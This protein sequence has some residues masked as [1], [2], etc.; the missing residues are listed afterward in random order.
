MISL[1]P[2]KGKRVLVLGEKGFIGR[3]LVAQLTAAGADA[4]SEGYFANLLNYEAV[5]RKV[6]E[7]EPDYIINAA[8]RNGGVGYKRPLTIFQYNTVI[9]LTILNVA[10]GCGVEK[11]LMPVASCAYDGAFAHLDGISS[12]AFLLG[13]P[14]ESIE[15]HGYAK[16]ATQLACKFAR[17]QHGLRAVTVCPSTVFGSGDRYGPDRSKI[18]AGMVKRFADAADQGLESVTCWGTGKPLREYL[19]VKDCASLMLQALVAYEDSTK[20]LNLGGSVELSIKETAETVAAEAGYRGSILW[21]ESKPDGQYRKWLDTRPMRE[22][23]G[24]QQYTDFRSALRETIAAYRQDRDR[25]TL[26]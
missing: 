18:L 11:V 8:G 25:G 14:H 21:D 4:R 15:A 26:R 24:P 12:D 7:N 5:Y 20:P 10:A 23:L 16:R 19:Y 13:K 3:E 2:L 9:P 17:E 1:E 22:L 6:L